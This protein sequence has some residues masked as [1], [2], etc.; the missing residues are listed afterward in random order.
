MKA[1]P[2]AGSNVLLLLSINPFIFL[3]DHSK[4]LAFCNLAC[5]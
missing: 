1:F 2:L 5:R 3:A 4:A